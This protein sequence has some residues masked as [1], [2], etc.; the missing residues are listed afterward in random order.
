MEVSD[1]TMA[2]PVSHSMGNTRQLILLVPSH[3]SATELGTNHGGE[4]ACAD[5]RRCEAGW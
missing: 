4:P 2:T 1:P 5:D 3:P